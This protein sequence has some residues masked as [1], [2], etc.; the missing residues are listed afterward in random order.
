[1]TENNNENSNYSYTHNLISSEKINEFLSSEGK[2]IRTFLISSI[3]TI[4]FCTILY[5]NYILLGEFFTT[6][7]LSFICSLALRP[8]K[9]KIIL[10]LKK[11]FRQ[12]HKYFVL[13]S[14]IIKVLRF[15]Q[16]IRLINF[17]N[18][19]IWKKQAFLRMNN[20]SFEHPQD[21]DMSEEEKSKHNFFNNLPFL[22]FICFLYIIIFKMRMFISA[23]IISIYFFIDFLVRLLIDM[24]IILSRKFS[25]NSL[26]LNKDGV[27]RDYVHT[28][29]SSLLILKYL[30]IMIF[31]IIIGVVLFYMDLKKIYIYLNENN[32]FLKLI[33]E[34]LLSSD[35]FKIYQQTI[36][37]QFNI[38]EVYLNSTY[39][40]IDPQF[41]QTSFL[42]SGNYTVYG[43][44][45]FY[46]DLSN[47]IINVLND[48][49]FVIE[50]YAP[51]NPNN[52][53]L[54]KTYCEEYENTLIF[55]LRKVFTSDYIER[56][57]CGS[58]ILLKQLN[59]D[60]YK[61]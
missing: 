53:Y 57:H 1:M 2:V 58:R 8:S 42:Q 5:F 55:I 29:V 60:V 9:D 6:L 20:E 52:T 61:T 3:I 25:N 38:I 28:I 16:I 26:V 44:F 33:K 35:K 11:H 12:S 14:W 43:K 50:G 59:I 47:K 13:R 22:L 41:P 19:K 7:F 46:I 10:K 56:F 27:P 49:T 32:D 18:S 31:I 17:I 15:L 34:N 51:G 45:W 40:S 37:E 21:S 39:I 30:L 4:V 48:P 54:Y 36:F 23:T 24:L